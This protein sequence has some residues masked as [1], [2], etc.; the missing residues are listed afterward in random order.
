M[1]PNG[2]SVIP[3]ARASRVSSWTSGLSREVTLGTKLQPE[4]ARV[5]VQRD[6][7]LGEAIG[8][9]TDIGVRRAEYF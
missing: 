3:L 8:P 9:E 5:T 2:L 4:G 6:A 1:R 7:V